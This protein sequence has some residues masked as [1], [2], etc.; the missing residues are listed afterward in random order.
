L[1]VVGRRLSIGADIGGN[2]QHPIRT[3]RQR[4]T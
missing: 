3:G 4:P 1:I 2:R